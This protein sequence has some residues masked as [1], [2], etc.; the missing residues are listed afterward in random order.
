VNTDCKVHNL[1]GYLKHHSGNS[2]KI[3]MS[4]LTHIG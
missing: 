1:K 4:G 3:V 2:H